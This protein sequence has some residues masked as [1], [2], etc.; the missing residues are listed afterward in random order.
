MKNFLDLAKE[1]YSV[2]SFKSTPVEQEKIDLILEAAKVAPT[3]RNNQPQK[4]FIIKSEEKRRQI[5]EITP[6][7][8][9]APLIFAIGYD[10]EIASTGII[11]EGFNFGM[12]DSTIACTQMMLEA[13][14]LGLGSC[15]VGRFKETELAAILGTSENIRLC[16]LLPVGYP[17]DDAVP[18][19]HHGECRDGSEMFTFL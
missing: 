10:E 12:I 3:A 18:S 7:S 2:R 19:A 1:R 6:F 14:E 9:D 17:A 11:Y 5:A 13:Q 8:F 15:W 4:I 16:A